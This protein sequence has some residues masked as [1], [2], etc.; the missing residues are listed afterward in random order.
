MAVL[1][2]DVGEPPDEGRGSVE[3]ALLTSR[4]AALHVFTTP[5]PR[6]GS[7]Q[8]PGREPIFETGATGDKDP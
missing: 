6:S 7:L 5:T 8:Q 4:A 3:A 2:F 1:S